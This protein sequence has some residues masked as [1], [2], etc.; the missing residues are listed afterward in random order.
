MRFQ[1]QKMS[2]PKNKQNKSGFWHDAK[3]PVAVAHRGGNLAGLSKE[4]S[5]EAFKRAY[6]AG[7]R[8]FE[9][10]VVSTRDGRLLAIHGRGY[11]RR[12]NKD[13]PAR[14]KVQLI[15]YKYAKKHIKVGGEEVATLDELL[16]KFPDARFFI[17]P[18]TVK[19]AYVLAKFLESR[20]KDLGRIYVGSFVPFNNSIVYKRLKEN[21]GREVGLG[22]LG[23]I[24][25]V[26]V[27][28]ASARWLPLGKLLAKVYV[29]WSRSGSVTVP[30]SWVISGS[31]TNF[32]QFAHQIGLKVGVYTP[33]SKRHINKCVNRG[34]DFIITDNLNDLRDINIK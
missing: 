34:V 30:Y 1:N 4:N 16:D 25:A 12:P 7:F 3:L 17:D 20:Q 31:G 2:Q 22:L 28:V 33:N 26:P 5:V 19:T 32:V 11:Q 13:L 23:P 24:K 27:R 9:T 29:A 10:D 8:W 21:T 15:T 14:T 6:N 18:K